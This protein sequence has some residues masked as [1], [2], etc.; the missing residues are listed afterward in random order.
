MQE[1]LSDTPEDDRIR[2]TK[3][4]GQRKLKNIRVSHR[5]LLHA[6]TQYLR[7]SFYHG[8][9]Y[10]HSLPSRCAGWKSLGL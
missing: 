9:A 2:T 6:A 4:A 8:W 10:C 5:V 7:I 3:I 1:I